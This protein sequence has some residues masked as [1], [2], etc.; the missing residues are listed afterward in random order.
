[1]HGEAPKTQT[2]DFK[3]NEAKL[4]NTAFVPLMRNGAE[5]LHLWGSAGSGKSRFAMQKEI[6]K[7]FQPARR[8]RKTIIARKVFNTLKDSCYSELKAV[9]YAWKLE[10]CFTILKSP[11]SITNNRTGVEFLFRGFDDVE[12]IKSISGADRAVYEE[13]TEAEQKEEITQL[14]TRLRGF[15]K[16]QVTLCYNPIDE[17]H[18][19]NE[20]YHEQKPVGHYFHH[21]TYL[22]NIQMPGR[23]VYAAFLESTKDSDP[24]YHRVYALGLWGQVV[25]GLIYPQSTTGAE[26]PK[27]DKGNDDIQF[28]GLDFGFSDPCALVA[29]HVRDALPKKD[30]I[31]KEVLYE[32]GLDGPN[33]VRR[34]NE[35]GVRKDRKII[36]DSARPEMI[37]S[38]KDAGYNVVACEK[39]TGSVLT[40]INRIRKYNIVIA[41]GSKNL[42]KEVHNYKKNQVRGVWVE[43]PAPT[44]VDHGMDAMRYGEQTQGLVPVNILNYRI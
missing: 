17:H 35:I 5:F 38:L 27:D 29:Q 34:F 11:L 8:N 25:E 24:N 23:D 22:D 12:K 43:D 19:I 32:T 30:L 15:D 9:I 2:F 7:S 13:T 28:Y 41:S 16:V 10:D 42:V 14:R 1:M 40:G 6:V 26:F 4:F 36:A 39:G 3:T 20:E 31:N 44:Q 21:S 37:Q 33:L 18:F